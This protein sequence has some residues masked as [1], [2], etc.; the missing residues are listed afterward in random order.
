MYDSDEC[1]AKLLFM[2]QQYYLNILK[3]I[4]MLLTI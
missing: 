1:Y 3:K 2:G 4:M